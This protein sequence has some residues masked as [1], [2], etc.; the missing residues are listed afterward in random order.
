[1]DFTWKHRLDPSLCQVLHQDHNV[2]IHFFLYLMNLY[3]NNQ[4]TLA[5]SEDIRDESFGR[6]W[7]REVEEFPQNPTLQ[8]YWSYVNNLYVYPDTVIMSGLCYLLY[9]RYI[10]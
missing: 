7:L 8:P 1:M 2:Y 10:I 6:E 3:I 5:Q 9:H 4:F